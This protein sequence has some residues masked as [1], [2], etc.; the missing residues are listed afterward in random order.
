MNYQSLFDVVIGNLGYFQPEIILG[1]GFLL[2]LIIDLFLKKEQSPIIAFLSLIVLVFAFFAVNA[3]SGTEQSLFFRM[4]AVDS[5]SVFFKYIFLIS[6]AITILISLSSAELK[7][8]NRRVGEYYII[9]VGLTFG[10]VLMSGATNLLM[11]FLAIELVSMASYVLVSF[12]KDDKKS[13]ES[14]LKYIIYGAFSSGLMIYGMSLIYG[15]TG[16]LDIADINRFLSA[17]SV[18]PVLMTLSILLVLGGFG[19]K[20]AAVPF[21]FWSPDVYEGAPTPITAF[22]SVGPKAAGFALILRFFK[23][24]FIS[25]SIPDGFESLALVD[26]TA[27]IAAMAV[28]TMT[29]GNVSALWQ[30]NVK[31]MFAYSSIA[32]A[33]Y[34]LMGVLL[35]SDHGT[36]AVLFYLTYYML[37]N[38]GAFF[39]IM[40]IANKTNS[41]ELDDLRGMGMRAPILAIPLVVFLAS[42]TGIP[43]T[44]GFAGK[45]MLFVAVLE[46]GNLYFWLAIIAVINSAISAFYYFKIV[47]MMFL[48][49]STED[50]PVEVTVS[51][52]AAI[53]LILLTIP[54]I[55]LG[56]Y[57]Q[58][59]YDFALASVRMIS[60]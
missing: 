27:I 14:G 3:Q 34:L 52:F 54:T 48:K 4:Y 45:F 37:M 17:N 8:N 56:L 21:H 7:K 51:P 5:Y 58:P 41:F 33:G 47:K 19:Y 20:I 35:L 43:G 57:W 30:T 28:L 39:A 11:M 25:H 59:L 15:A 42:L 22:L 26:W 31:R 50:N 1:G 60:M 53:L 16:T 13:N 29:V 32:H 36:A 2:L 23:G 18:S 40:L 24:M 12:L 6:A 55:V 49:K 10:M 9:L 38:L 44:V 46:K